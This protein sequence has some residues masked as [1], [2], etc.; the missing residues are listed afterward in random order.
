MAKGF[1]ALPAESVTIH[2]QKKTFLNHPDT[3]KI[4][5]H[6]SELFG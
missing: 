4:E 5:L 2:Q 6:P 3:K 1:M